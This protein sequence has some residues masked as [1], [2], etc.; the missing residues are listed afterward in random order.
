MRLASAYANVGGPD[1]LILRA[2]GKTSSQMATGNLTFF[3]FLRAILKWQTESATPHPIEHVFSAFSFQKSR[4]M[5][6]QNTFKKKLAGRETTRETVSGHAL[7]E[8]L[9]YYGPS[10]GAKKI[11]QQQ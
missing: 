10:A 6:C 3:R 1:V 9:N 8:V 5:P 2:R 11:M 7:P 4:L